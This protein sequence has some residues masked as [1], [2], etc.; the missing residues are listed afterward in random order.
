MKVYA[1]I[2]DHG[3]RPESTNEA[4]RVAT[5][6]ENY[7][8]EAHV[9]RLSWPEGRPTS[10]F[11]TRARTARYQALA[12]ACVDHDVRH[13]LL[14]HHSDDLAETVMMRMI[15]SSRAEGLRGMKHTS[16]IPEASRI[17]GSENLEIGRPFLNV[18][19]IRLK[20]TCREDQVQWFEDPTNQDPSFTKRNTIRTLLFSQTTRSRL[21]KALQKPSL[22]EMAH[23]AAESDVT[24]THRAQRV[25]QDCEL[26]FDGGT[27]ALQMR[28]PVPVHETLVSLGP[29]NA[30]VMLKSLTLIAEKVT[31]L[32]KVKRQSMIRVLAK[33]F[34]HPHTTPVTFTAAGLSWTRGTDRIWT[35]R[36]VPH[37][38]R[39]RVDATMDFQLEGPGI[40]SERKLWDGRWWVR[41]RALGTEVGSVVMRPLAPVEIKQ[42]KIKLKEMRRNDI[43]ENHLRKLPGNHLYTVP[44]LAIAVEEGI[45]GPDGVFRQFRERTLLGLPTFNV[46]LMKRWDWHKSPAHSREQ[47]LVEWEVS[48]R[49]PIYMVMAGVNIRSPSESVL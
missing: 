47:R 43:L 34:E 45:P 1:F 12:K 11:E 9:L 32:S 22:L 17:Y 29:E 20:R 25:L 27:G 44:V 13:L 26:V 37:S 10:A 24:I 30:R 4:R 15:C 40:W 18:S 41:V 48:F 35:L 49:L 42:L 31:P 21:P 36:R 38:T 3:V 2:V 16:R 8:F 19:K 6:M 33:I 23:R 7:R 39:S 28:L 5:I 46:H 14:G